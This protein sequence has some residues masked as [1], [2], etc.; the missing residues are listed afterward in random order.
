MTQQPI[1]PRIEQILSQIETY[2]SVA[3]DYGVPAWHAMPIASNTAI[4]FR[5]N[6]SQL[7]AVWQGDSTAWVWD[8]SNIYTT[9]ERALMTPGMALELQAAGVCIT[10][11]HAVDVPLVSTDEVFAKFTSARSGAVALI[12]DSTTSEPAAPVAEVAAVETSASVNFTALFLMG[13][14]LVF[15]V[16]GAKYLLFKPASKAAQKVKPAAPV[17]TAENA[18]AEASGD[19]LD[20]DFE[21]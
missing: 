18:E 5:P 4:A 2:Q 20:Y 19:A 16:V 9:P 3:A 17:A 10:G 14:V 6:C 11:S 1:D 13:C 7:E 21:L 8:G 15:L 12:P